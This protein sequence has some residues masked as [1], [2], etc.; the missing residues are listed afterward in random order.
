MCQNIY[1]QAYLAIDLVSKLPS[2]CIFQSLVH[3]IQDFTV[4]VMGGVW[5]FVWRGMYP[6]M[7]VGKCWHCQQDLQT[8][9]WSSLPNPIWN[10]LNHVWEGFHIPCWDWTIKP[11]T[12]FFVPFTCSSIYW[13]IKILFPREIKFENIFFPFKLGNKISSHFPMFRCCSQ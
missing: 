5:A 8:M 2:L 6:G 4:W 13:K 10:F 3:V 7:Q 11:R 1:N 12:G 9:H